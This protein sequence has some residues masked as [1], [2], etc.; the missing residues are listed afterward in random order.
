V[1]VLT[2]VVLA[3][4]FKQFADLDRNRPALRR[5]PIRRTVHSTSKDQGVAS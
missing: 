4:R 2:P 3:S 1:R 5:E